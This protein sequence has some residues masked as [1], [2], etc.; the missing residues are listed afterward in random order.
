MSRPSRI[1]SKFNE[2]R[3]NRLFIDFI[4]HIGDAQIPYHKLVLGK[5]SH[6]FLSLVESMPDTTVYHFTPEFNPQEMLEPI[7]NFLYGNKLEITRSN[8]VAILAISD[9][10]QIEAVKGIALQR[11]HVLFSKET[12]LQFL[13]ECVDYNAT[14]F[15]LELVPLLAEHFD[16]FP[17]EKVYTALNPAILSATLRHPLQ[18]KRSPD[19]RLSIVDEFH[20]R[21]PIACAADQESLAT[22]VDWLHDGAHEYLVHHNCSWMPPR[23]LRPLYRTLMKCR[24]VTANEFHHRAAI[25]RDQTSRWFP[26][27]W[28]QGV[29]VGGGAGA[30]F[31]VETI[32]F[33]RTLGGIVGDFGPVALGT[34]AVRSSAG[35]MHMPAEAALNGKPTEYFLSIDNTGNPFMELDLGALVLF[36]PSSVTVVCST[37]EFQAMKRRRFRKEAPADWSLGKKERHG[38]D[39]G[40][41]PTLCPLPAAIMI[42]GI[43][44]EEKVQ[45]LYHGEYT[46][47]EIPVVGARPLERIRIEMPTTKSKVP[48][49]RI[50]DI[51]LIGEYLP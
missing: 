10:Y 17:R 31:S 21:F 1:T 6:F 32:S 36:R 27:T 34:I 47:N 15:G 50:F 2:F 7:L 28:V 18:A 49:F 12:L 24:R 4:L 3:Q 35:M 43:D 16:S 33:M 38:V 23:I 13:K 11:F 42:S 9:F 29:Y 14:K 44:E 19:D 51:Q 8:V 46:G 26:F 40:D 39:W 5:H 37:N 20:A 30:D 48:I 22:V 45:V 41:G 25:C